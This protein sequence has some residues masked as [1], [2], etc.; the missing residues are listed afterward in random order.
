MDG[1]KRITEFLQKLPLPSPLASP[2]IAPDIWLEDLP[3]W[4]RPQ[5]FRSWSRKRGV[6]GGFVS[7]LANDI[8]M[9]YEN[10]T[11]LTANSFFP[12]G[13]FLFLGRLAMELFAMAGVIEL[14]ST[15]DLRNVL[16]MLLP[17]RWGK[18]RTFVEWGSRR[19]DS[20]F[21]CCCPSSK[22]SKDEWSC[23]IEFPKVISGL[24][25]ESC[26]FEQQRQP[27]SFLST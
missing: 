11:R 5:S 25:F 22:R 19:A 14:G 8:I 26:V 10:R 4:A 6:N 15:W 23:D 16:R 27:D 20:F 24:N 12:G 7:N 13:K 2:W 1:W 18:L 3:S 21:N 9:K 17:I